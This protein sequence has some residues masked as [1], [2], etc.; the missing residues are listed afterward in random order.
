MSERYQIAAADA[1]PSFY[2]TGTKCHDY[3]GPISQDL[4]QEL[5]C[6]GDGRLRGAVAKAGNQA[7][8]EGAARARQVDDLFLLAPGDIFHKCFGHL[9]R[10][11]G[12][13]ADHG[14]PHLV[15]DCAKVLFV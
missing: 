8:L 4:G 15:I 9:D 6:F 11:K 13:G 3:D 5:H 7:L 12:V 2:V 14:I 1:N 10:G